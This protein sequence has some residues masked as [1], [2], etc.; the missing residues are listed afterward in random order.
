MGVSAI[1]YILENML[2]SVYQVPP[3]FSSLDVLATVFCLSIYLSC[4][5]CL[6]SL[7]IVLL[8]SLS[9]SPSFYHAVYLSS[10][11]SFVLCIYC[12]INFA[13]ILSIVYCSFCLLFCLC[14]YRSI[15][16]PIV[17]EHI[18]LS[19]GIFLNIQI[20]L[21]Q[22]LISTFYFLILTPLPYIQI[23]IAV[24]YPITL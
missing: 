4:Y 19:F 5:L 15:V 8:F 24:L 10:Y 7:S 1:Y 18:V 3:P 16:T 13:I 23:W 12:N 2:F 6:L 11:R 20:R 22:A 17:I 14:S 9:F 21:C